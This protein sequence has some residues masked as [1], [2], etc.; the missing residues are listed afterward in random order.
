MTEELRGTAFQRAVERRAPA[1]RWGETADLAGAC[2]FLAS[3][4]SDHGTGV[5]IPVDGGYLAS[6]GLERA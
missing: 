1:G 5:V 6:D 4:A 3:P 2:L